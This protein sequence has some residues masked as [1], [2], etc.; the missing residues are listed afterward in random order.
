MQ[1]IQKI[2]IYSKDEKVTQLLKKFQSEDL[3]LY[4]K[5]LN[6]ME[7]LGSFRIK[8]KVEI[9]E[10]KDTKKEQYIKLYCT[11]LNE[12]FFIF[13][14]SS[15][16]KED[17]SKIEKISNEENNIYDISLAKKFE[18][19]EKNIN[20]LKVNKIYNFRHGRFITDEETYYNVFLGD[21][22]CYQIE[23][24]SDEKI[25]AS[26]LLTKLNK[27]EKAPTLK[28]YTDILFKVMLENNV[29]YKKIELG[30]YKNFEI[31]ESIT[32]EGIKELIKKK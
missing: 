8:N 19:T 24:D 7:L 26:E 3:K 9:Y 15:T 5:I 1:Q 22:V 18:I 29:K 10:I 20:L 21:N 30:V 4:T 13:C 11:D 25:S 6:T 2:Y 31:I 27:L 23:I 16:K 32:I 28:E 17:K 12:N 14:P